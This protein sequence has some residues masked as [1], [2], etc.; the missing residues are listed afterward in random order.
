MQ[1]QC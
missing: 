1:G